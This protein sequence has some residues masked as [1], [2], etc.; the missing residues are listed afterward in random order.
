MLHHTLFPKREENEKPGTSGIK[1]KLQSGVRLALTSAG[2]E[3]D[4]F[5]GDGRLLKG[6][7]TDPILGPGYQTSQFNGGLTDM[8][9]SHRAITLG[10]GDIRQVS[11]KPGQNDLLSQKVGDAFPSM[12]WGFMLIETGKPT[13]TL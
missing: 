9:W 1:P 8:H 3:G 11:I 2:L 10:G 5:A 13:P 12:R 7:Y 6:K 4:I